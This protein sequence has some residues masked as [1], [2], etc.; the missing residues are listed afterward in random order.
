MEI[1]LLS[2]YNFYQSKNA[3]VHFKVG[4]LMFERIEK[5]LERSRFC[6]CSKL[7]TTHSGY[8]I[9]KISELYS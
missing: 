8:R 5:S 6:G 9:E 1:Q 4:E 2:S 3:D 7:T